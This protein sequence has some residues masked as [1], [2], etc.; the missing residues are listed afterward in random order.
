MRDAQIKIICFNLRG[1]LKHIRAL[2]CRKTIVVRG[3]S[4]RQLLVPESARVRSHRISEKS[5]QKQQH[6]SVPH[7]S[8]SFTAEIALIDVESFHVD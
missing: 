8:R 3:A 1:K 4:S 5:A 6:R 2:S 7:C